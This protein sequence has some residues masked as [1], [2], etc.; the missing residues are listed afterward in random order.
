[1]AVAVRMAIAIG[2]AVA[3][4]MAVGPRRQ[5]PEGDRSTTLFEGF[6]GGFQNADDLQA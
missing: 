4:G 2:M 3:V 5:R 1:M 6:T